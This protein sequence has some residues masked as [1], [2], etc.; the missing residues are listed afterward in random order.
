MNDIKNMIESTSDMFTSMNDIPDIT[1]NKIES[2][3]EIKEQVSNIIKYCLK[4]ENNIMRR[5]NIDQYKQICMR[6][7]TDFHQKYPTLFF[8]IIENP[9]SFPLY[10]LDEMLQLKKKIEENEINEEK[11]S[12][13]LGQKYYNEFVK[14]T[15]SELDKDIKK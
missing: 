7:F 6:L 5:D 2:S 10:R 11:A 13:H 8:S 9:S 15:V 14:N 4:K 12:V 3:S 1:Q